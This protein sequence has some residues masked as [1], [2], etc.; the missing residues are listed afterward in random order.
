M[1]ESRISGKIIR[2]ANKRPSCKA[3]KIH[4]GVYTTKGTPDIHITQR[5]RSYWLETK[6]PEKRR[7]AKKKQRYEL[8]R[9]KAAGALTAVVCSWE[10]V[11]E[12]L[13]D[14]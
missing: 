12:I 7:T 11:E 5:G 14:A 4:G 3:I 13:N 1:P 2:N 6:T 10:E 9:W 8:S